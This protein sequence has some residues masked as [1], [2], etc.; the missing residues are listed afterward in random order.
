MSHVRKA[1][2]SHE[3]LKDIKLEVKAG[4][5]CCIIGPSGSSKSTA[6]RCLN[7]LVT[8][9]GGEAIV[10]GLNV[11][12]PRVS[13]VELCRHVGMVFQGFNLF[14]HMSALQNL[15]LGPNKVRGMS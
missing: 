14:P 10:D 7:R 1:L 5:V 8:I 9:D 2:G 12:D 4:D 3:V 6:L 13:D 11:S 15:T